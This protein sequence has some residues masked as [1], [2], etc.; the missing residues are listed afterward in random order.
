MSQETKREYL[1][2]SNGVHPTGC[3]VSSIYVRMY[4][5]VAKSFQGRPRKQ[6]SVRLSV[7]L[8]SGDYSSGRRREKAF[9]KLNGTSDIE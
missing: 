8:A 7:T 6:S 2:E 4:T 1:A 9:N 3:I 5:V